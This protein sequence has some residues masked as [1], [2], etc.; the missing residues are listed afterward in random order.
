MR[1]TV[2]DIQKV[3]NLYKLFQPL[4]FKNARLVVLEVATRH[5]VA[6]K[7]DCTALQLVNDNFVKRNDTRLAGQSHL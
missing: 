5:V 4:Q 1:A 7:P 2:P 3:Y 6:G